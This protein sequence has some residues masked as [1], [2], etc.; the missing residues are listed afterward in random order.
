M[1]RKEGKKNK[2]IKL[3]INMRVV[4]C[5]NMSCTEFAMKNG[6]FCMLCRYIILLKL[7]KGNAAS[8]IKSKF[9][10]VEMYPPT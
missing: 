6:E 10:S 1:L 5:V 7:R 9:D 8:E 3:G 4:T 2:I